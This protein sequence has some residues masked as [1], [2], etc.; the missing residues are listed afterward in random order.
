MAFKLLKEN[1]G[2]LLIFL[3]VFMSLNTLT[4]SA[5]LNEE[6]AADTYSLNRAFAHVEQMSQAS[7]DWVLKRILMF[8]DI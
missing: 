1:L 8:E 7:T 5:D 6:V 3:A 2:V 4:P